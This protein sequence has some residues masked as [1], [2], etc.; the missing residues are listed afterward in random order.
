MRSSSLSVEG[1]GGDMPQCRHL[2]VVLKFKPSIK[3]L[4]RLSG[5][6]RFMARRFMAPHRRRRFRAAESIAVRGSSGARG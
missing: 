3:K 6:L 4:N 1:Y 2:A 5:R